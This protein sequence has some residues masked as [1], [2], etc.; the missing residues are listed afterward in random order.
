VKQHVNVW[1]LEDCIK[2]F[3]GQKGGSA[4]AA[5]REDCSISQITKVKQLFP[6]TQAENWEVVCV[7]FFVSLIYFFIMIS[8]HFRV[9]GG[10]ISCEG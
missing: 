7:Y 1:L 9:Q 2:V 4:S 8:G 10:R 6:S 3:G 5:C